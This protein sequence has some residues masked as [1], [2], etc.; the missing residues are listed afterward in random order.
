MLTRE[1]RLFTLKLWC[2]PGVV[3]I[4]EAQNGGLETSTGVMGA[5]SVVM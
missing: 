5:Y 1:S 2:S 3:V 4:M